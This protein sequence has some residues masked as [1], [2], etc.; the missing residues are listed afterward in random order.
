MV[1]E[2]LKIVFKKIKKDLDERTGELD[3]NS[4]VYLITIQ[5]LIGFIGLVELLFIG[6]V[7]KRRFKEK[8]RGSSEVF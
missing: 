1:R 7:G 4:L 5:L 6:R 2:T 3:E 8:K